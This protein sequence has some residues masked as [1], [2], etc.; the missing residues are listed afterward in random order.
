[1]NE[2]KEV[3]A[4][5]DSSQIT[6]NEASFDPFSGATAVPPI[7]IDALCHTIAAETDPAM[8]G[9][10]WKLLRQSAPSSKGLDLALQFIMNPSASNRGEAIRY[11]RVCFPDRLPG[12]LEAFARDP[13]E[14]V[15][16]QLS[17]FLRDS[18][19][20]AAV[21]MKINMLGKASPERQEILIKEIGELGNLWH[22]EALNGLA[23]MVD[24]E[25]VFSRAAEQ[26]AKRAKAG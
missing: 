5:P 15:R 8:Q 21:G 9:L 16:Y 19:C 7:P 1:M 10:Y 23:R 4:S 24:G 2:E 12:L 13:D 3:P 11:L 14:E 6:E 22:W 18:D 17:E 26:L 25:S 20:E